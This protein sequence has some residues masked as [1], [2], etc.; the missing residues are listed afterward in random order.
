MLEFFFAGYLNVKLKTEFGD[1]YTVFSGGDDFFLIGPWNQVIDFSYLI[2]KEFTNFCAEN[3]DMKFSSGIIL[4]KPHE[5]ISYCTKIVEEKL[6]Q[7]KN[8]VEKDRITLFGQTINWSELDKI[9][10]EAQNVI[11]W[12]EKKPPIVSRGF[13]HNLQTYGEM[14]QRYKETKDT[15]WLK[16]IPLLIHDINRN[17]TKRE[18]TDAYNWAINLS[19]TIKKEIGEDNLPY[20]KTIIEYV[21]TYTRGGFHV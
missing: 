10:E 5:P 14:C 19:P 9:L 17:L 8:T 11:D 12:L 1:I 20:L 3:P 16:F 13:V 15:R 21:L 4:S 2:R 7:S 6:R 18:Q